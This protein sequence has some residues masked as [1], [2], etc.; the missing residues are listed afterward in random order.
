MKMKSVNS[1]TNTTFSIWF[2]A[3][4]LLTL[5]AMFLIL[6]KA[7]EALWVALAALVVVCVE[8]RSEQTQ[9]HRKNEI[10][11]L[12]T[13]RVGEVTG[14]SFRHFPLPM[15]IMGIDGSILWHNGQFSEI[16]GGENRFG[17]R[18][19][20]VF[21]DIDVLKII[22][23]KKQSISFTLSHNERYYE[24]V[25]SIIETMNPS[26]EGYS[27]VLYFIDRT[28]QKDMT[29]KCDNQSLVSAILFIDNYEELLKNTVG[30]HAPLMAAVERSIVQWGE[31]NQALLIKYEKD[32]YRI[33]MDNRNLKIQ[34]DNKFD[35]IETIHAIEEGNRIPVTVSIGI[36][37]NGG[38]PQ[39]NDNL[40]AAAVEMALGR[41][42]DQVVIKNGEK[43]KF[44]GGGSQELE[45]RT[46]VKPRVVAHALRELIR[47]RDCVIIMGHRNADADVIGAAVGLAAIMRHENVNVKI[48]MEESESNMTTGLVEALITPENGYT[49]VFIG[50]KEALTIFTANSVLIVVDTHK[51][52]MVISP[53]LLA[54]S[55]QTVVIDHHRR[56]AEFIENV[57]SYHEPYASS[58]SEMV[59][60]I[61]Q[62]MEENPKLTQAEAQALYAGIAVD[63]KNF[64]FKTG[65][66]TFEAATFLR[67][68][69][70]DTIAVKKLFQN[71]RE[72]YLLRAKIV[73]TSYV[74]HD[75]I[76]IARYTG[77]DGEYSLI[78]SRAADE[79]LNISGVVA[80]FVLCQVGEVV[81]ISGRSLAGVNV[82]LILEELGGG[83]HLTVA[84]AQVHGDIEEVEHNLKAAI[85]SIL[86]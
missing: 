35:F 15:V 33:I 28:T 79:L 83:G 62:Y 6:G 54:K 41:G 75:N 18:I 77:S 66:R 72:D 57:L 78:I 58:T 49:D 84:G 67:R 60:E 53:E 5:A 23:E 17:V 36:G 22:D 39:E 1:K 7:M 46:K 8:I 44:F 20:E 9:K 73:A 71:D 25:G 29:E 13:T 82:Q 4:I 50:E 52:D 34:I 64:V 56:A 68:I 43:F 63:S 47:R 38:N 37:V 26:G 31:E 81:A 16:S 74:Y 42:G 85:D 19:S 59:T 40:A 86:N 11:Q 2:N 61:I 51:P 45:K 65:V 48:L 76:A 32:K 24:V 55:E 80:S 30:D 10:V 70:V 21:S 14:E 69:G 12:I 3:T 27:L